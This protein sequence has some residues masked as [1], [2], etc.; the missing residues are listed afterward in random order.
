MFPD[1]NIGYLFGYRAEIGDEGIIV[2]FLR[3]LVKR[4]KATTYTGGRIS[5]KIW[6]GKC[7]RVTRGIEI[8]L[9]SGILR[10][11]LIVFEDLNSAVN[12]L[13]KHIKVIE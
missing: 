13:K 8:A 9:K 4:A 6:W 11:H 10:R 12:G 1:P 3:E 7:S 5:W 2:S